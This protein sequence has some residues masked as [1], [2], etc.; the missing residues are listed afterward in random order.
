V[1]IKKLDTHTLRYLQLSDIPAPGGG[2]ARPRTA[3][4]LGTVPQEEAPAPDPSGRHGPGIGRG[5]HG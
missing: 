1:I 5:R 3:G 4:A 2:G